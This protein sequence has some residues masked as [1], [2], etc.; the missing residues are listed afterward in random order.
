MANEYISRVNR[1][2]DYIDKNIGEDLTLDELAGVACFSKY[3]FH[4]VFQSITR[5][6]LYQFILRL[7]LE[8]AAVLLLQERTRPITA[9][10]FDC[11]FSDSSIF[12]RNFKTAFGL[13]ASGWRKAKRDSLAFGTRRPEAH[14]PSC[15]INLA[16]TS[17]PR[18]YPFP[19]KPVVRI[20]ERSTV[21]VVY[22]RHTGPYKGDANLF[23]DLYRQLFDWA[24]KMA[25]PDKG[26][27]ETMVIY[28]DPPEITRDDQLRISICL[29]VEKDVRGDGKIGRMEIPGG[30]YALID[31][32]L[33]LDEYQKAWDWVYCDW[34]PYSGYQ[35]DSRPVFELYPDQTNAEKGKTLVSI[36]VPI[37][38]ILSI[39]A[40]L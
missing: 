22:I 28:H 2:I 39:S 17:S 4:R 11:G 16:S 3:H 32:Q 20:M 23:E 24:G 12:A 14:N 15:R 5:E 7:R 25:R 29:P 40:I 18:P 8:K 10:A 34:L 6:P 26:V 30:K 36:S 13:S 21:P 1:V 9:I 31:F 27:S 35:P 19:G 37:K 38:P 33:G